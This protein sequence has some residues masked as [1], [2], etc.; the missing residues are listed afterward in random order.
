[1]NSP[2]K[3]FGMFSLLLAFQVCIANTMQSKSGYKPPKVTP[4]LIEEL[5]ANTLDD[6]IFVKGGD[7][8]MG[9]DINDEVLRENLKKHEPQVIEFLNSKKGKL[10]NFFIT[11]GEA[12]CSPRHKVSL[13][14]YS[15]SK[16]EVS[17][18]EFDIFT[19]DAKLPILQEWFLQ[20]TEIHENATDIR[21]GDKGAI[22]GWNQAQSYCAW[23]AD[24]T[25]LN[26]SLPTEAQWE[27]AATSRGRY[28]PFATS[29]GYYDYG[30]NYYIADSYR[31]E[32]STEDIIVES[33][34]N[35]YKVNQAIYPPNPLG[36]Y[37]MSGSMSEWVQDWYD[38]DYYKESPTKNPMGPKIGK[39]KVVRGG[40]K[41]GTPGFNTVWRRHN[42]SILISEED[43]QLKELIVYGGSHKLNRENAPDNSIG[44]RCAL[45][46][47][48]PVSSKD[49]KLK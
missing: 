37:N 31:S 19:Q 43:A 15:I 45:N 27:Y 47:P 4:Q 36:V 20:A 42:E 26:F 5:L 28:M 9:C 44:M 34:E 3:F 22:T 38:P 7:F 8:I 2:K 40:S 16:F 12:N 24:K 10:I 6:M 35:E 18:R 32:S 21:E 29:T 11:G 1:M 13:D 14:N 49:L 17:F 30:V 25:G 48:I 41:G 23:L 46:H 33:D 39:T